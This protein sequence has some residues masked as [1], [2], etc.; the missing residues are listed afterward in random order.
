MQQ[1]KWERRSYHKANLCLMP[2]IIGVLIFFVIPF[3]VVIYYSFIDDVISK[4][5]VFLDNFINV[6]KNGA[7][8]QAAFNTIR[9]TAIAVPLAVILSLLMANLML[10]EMP[11]KSH[12]RTLYLSP[13][14]VPIASIVLIFQVLFHYNGVVNDFIRLFGADKIDWF[15]S[16]YAPVIIVIL[17]L[18]KNLGYN[19]VLFMAALSSV[20]KDVLEVARLDCSSS[21]KIFF[22]VKLRYLSPTILFVTILSIISS[23]KVFREVYLLTG[24]YPYESLYMLQHFMNN[25]FASLD[26]QKMSAAAVILFDVMVIIIGIL[27]VI[28][29]RY[30]KDVE[31]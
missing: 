27:F 6:L 10:S 3:C 17:F 12:F 21:I 30:G 15:K 29:N 14:M 18:W 31:S 8:R 1:S 4:E 26:Y 23:F 22:N 13:L 16:S 19:M 9:F 5:F 11:L 28:E 20:P 25:T 2:S 24:D 7:F